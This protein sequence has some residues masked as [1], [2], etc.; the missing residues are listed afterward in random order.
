[1]R[2][3][4]KP[5]MGRYRTQPG[6]MAV[7]SSLGILAMNGMGGRASRRS[8]RRTSMIEWEPIETAPRDDTRLLLW[9]PPPLSKP[10]IGFAGLSRTAT[11][12]PMNL[13]HRT[14]RLSRRR[15]A[16][17]SRL[18]L[19]HG[20]RLWRG[21]LPGRLAGR[22]M[23]SNVHPLIHRPNSGTYP[24]PQETA[25]RRHSGAAGPPPAWSCCGGSPGT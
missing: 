3:L 17:R 18:P 25:F 11:L 10:A 8:R 21:Y 5:R 23:G 1:V 12:R 20:L 7:S 22:P 9:L 13:Y 2:A 4:N 6:M 19:L 14:G 24:T 15:A 16:S